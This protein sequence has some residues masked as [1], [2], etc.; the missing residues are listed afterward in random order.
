MERRKSLIERYKRNTSRYTNVH[1]FMDIL[2]TI[3][4]VL[5]L[6]QVFVWDRDSLLSL[7]FEIFSFVF[8]IAYAVIL[9]LDVRGRL[10][11]DS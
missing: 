4:V 2:L 6:I 5:T 1:N 9:I 10:K 7:I 11:I 3:V 8:W